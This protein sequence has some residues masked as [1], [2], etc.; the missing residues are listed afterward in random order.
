MTKG[1]TPEKVPYRKPSISDFWE[2]GE[3]KTDKEETVKK[4]RTK[5]RKRVKSLSDLFET[6]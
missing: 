3:P 1:N 2:L 4:D 6:D 5:T